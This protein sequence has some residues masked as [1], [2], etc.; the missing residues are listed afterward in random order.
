METHIPFV[1]IP[2]FGL[3]SM[4][5]NHKRLQQLQR[6]RT[7]TTHVI[8]RVYPHFCSLVCKEHSNNPGPCVV[9]SSKVAADIE[10]CE[11]RFSGEPEL[12]GYL[13]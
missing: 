6:V 9:S 5:E 12:L 10:V 8:N 7:E 11:G 4:T 1:G 3:I 2:V 13:S